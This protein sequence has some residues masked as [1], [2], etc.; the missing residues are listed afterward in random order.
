[1]LCKTYPLIAIQPPQ[2]HS[3][4][5]FQLFLQEKPL[6]ESLQAS[7]CQPPAVALG[8]RADG[9]LT[10]WHVLP[11]SIITS[12]ILAGP[13]QIWH[14]FLAP[15]HLIFLVYHIPL[16]HIQVI[17]SIFTEPRSISCRPL[18]SESL[19]TRW[20]FSWKGLGRVK[21]CRGRSEGMPAQ[22][23]RALLFSAVQWTFDSVIRL[24]PLTIIIFLLT[25][26]SSFHYATVPASPVVLCYGFQIMFLAFGVKEFLISSELSNLW[27]ILLIA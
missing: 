2:L 14:S 4:R 21:Q 19:L 17:A 11:D 8:L 20:L 7:E 13:N 3:N 12:L 23:I 26:K 22:D 6:H 15:F 1:M 10:R 24:H 27:L 25:R 5:L 9:S 16:N 18:L